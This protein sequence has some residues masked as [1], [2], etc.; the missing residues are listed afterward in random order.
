M[1]KSAKKKK[2]HRAAP[3]IAITPVLS[4]GNLYDRPLGRPEDWYT[5]KGRL[6]SKPYEHELAQLQ[7]ELVKL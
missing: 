4:L 5:A 6:K 7:M 1:S 2:A 3:T